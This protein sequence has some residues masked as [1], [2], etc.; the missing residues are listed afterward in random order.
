MK[1]S[2][3]LATPLVHAMV[4]SPVMSTGDFI[5]ASA[6]GF[7]PLISGIAANS[8]P[9]EVRVFLTGT[10][11]NTGAGGIVSTLIGG[12]IEA[13]GMASLPC[14]VHAIEFMSI[15]AVFYTMFT[16]PGKVAVKRGSGN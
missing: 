6:N 16:W 14:F 3:F 2:A 5:Y 15:L 11:N 8:V 10:A 7:W 4:S 9:P 13:F 12:I 1:F